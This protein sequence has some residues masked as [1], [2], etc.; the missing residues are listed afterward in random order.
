[1]NNKPLVSC[2]IIFFN[3]GE[4]F[5]VEAIESVF[6]QTYD[7]WELLLS[8]DGSTDESTEIALRY[9]QKYPEKVRYLEHERHQNCGMSATRNLG[10][11][12]A[13]GE[14]IAFLDADDIWLPHKLDQ[15]VPILESHPEAAMLYGR[16]QVWFTWMENNP[17]SSWNPDN[18]QDDFMTITSVEFDTLIKPTKQLLLFLQNKEIYPCTCSILIR[19]QIFEEIG[20]FE[21]DFHNAHED[22]VFNSKLFLKAPVYVSS[23]CWDKYRIHPDSYWRRADMAGKGEQIRRIGHIKYLTWLE[24][25]LAEQEIKDPVIWKALEKALFPYHHP[26]LYYLLD[27]EKRIIDLKKIIKLTARYTLPD[28]IIRR[29][30]AKFSKTNPSHLNH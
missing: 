15:Q 3:A 1:M 25:Y 9:T 29:L 23:E 27:I 2:I 8:D 19:S 17:V 20:L 22:M 11:R 24:R 4:K 30:K 16:T 26:N 6:A 5:F 10:I 12:H 14:Y 18:A 21:E 7:H 28:P 13:K